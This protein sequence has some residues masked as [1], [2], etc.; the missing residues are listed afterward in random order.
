M[1]R[2]VDL[3]THTNASDGTCTPEELI[4][5]AEGKKLAAIAVT[6]HDTTQGVGRAAREAKKF[7]KLGF[8]PGIEI[9]AKSPS[10]TLHIIGLAIDQKS[11]ALGQLMAKLCEARD[12]R[13]PK[14][15][16]KLQ[17]MG[18]NIDMD[19]V[20][21]QARK[22]RSGRKGQIIGRLHIAQAMYSKSLVGSL[23]QAFSRYIGNGG[24]AFVDKERFE[25]K[26]AIEAIHKAGGLAILAHPVHLK[27]ENR[28]Q[29][30]RIVRSF[31][32]HGLDGMEVYHS[33]HS[34]QQTRL[35][36]DTAQKFKLA[37]S[38]GSDF[39]GSAKSGVI[40]GKPRVPVS[41]LTGKLS[42]W[43]S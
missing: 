14:I 19:D 40:L 17:V 29:L 38:G 12:E 41:V 36:L 7:P 9:S 20:L 24:P 43:V 3:H 4:Q 16:A 35:Y 33:D 26:E 10:G 31:I 23:D 37:V 15:V 18:M 34:A 11:K 25:P 28:A 2:F 1:R 5:L 13:N 27:C 32:R 8:I 30:E 6:D 22:S 21:A 39:H 42:Q